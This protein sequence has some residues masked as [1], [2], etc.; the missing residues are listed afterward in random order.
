M[1]TTTAPRRTGLLNQCQQLPANRLL[2][3]GVISTTVVKFSMICSHLHSYKYKLIRMQEREKSLLSL[4]P[5]LW[6]LNFKQPRGICKHVYLAGKCDLL[7]YQQPENRLKD[8]QKMLEAKMNTTK[9]RLCAFSVSH[10]CH[11][12]DI[13]EVVFNSLAWS[14]TFSKESEG[15]L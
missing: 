13:S 14:Q 11:P 7:L 1:G 10:L 2:G 15:E 4:G 8:T 12:R 5:A 9:M 3:M 6:N